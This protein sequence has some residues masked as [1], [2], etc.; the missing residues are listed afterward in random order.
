MVVRS[1]EKTITIFPELK[2]GPHF[3]APRDSA[4]FL[5]IHLD[6]I[7]T[8]QSHFSN[9]KQK[10]AVGIR[11]LNKARLYFFHHASLL[12]YLLFLAI[13]SIMALFHAATTLL[14]FHR[15]NI[16]KSVYLHYTVQF[17]PFLY[18]RPPTSE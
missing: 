13:I 9:L 18:L 1:F 8:Y 12:L 11:A 7:L 14:T 17:M 6:H 16:S 15:L 10:T 4:T 5:R 3:I 2:L